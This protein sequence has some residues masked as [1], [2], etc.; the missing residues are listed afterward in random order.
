MNIFCKQNVAI[1]KLGRARV[2]RRSPCGHSEV[3]KGSDLDPLENLDL[4]YWKDFCFFL[5]LF[6]FQ[7][8]PLSKINMLYVAY[9]A[10]WDLLWNDN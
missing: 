2:L 7:A 9:N 6:P 10:L 1:R 5:L 3:P 8:I 4:Y